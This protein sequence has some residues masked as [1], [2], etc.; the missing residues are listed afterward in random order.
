MTLT[1]PEVVQT[2]YAAR[3]ELFDLL[4][5]FEPGTYIEPEPAKT[6]VR[7]HSQ[8]YEHTLFEVASRLESGDEILDLGSAPFCTSHAFHRLGFTVTAADYKPDDWLDPEL[9]PYK[10]A[11][12]NCDG[13]ALPF[14]DDSFSA[15]VFTEIFEHLHVNL[16]FTMKEILRVLKPNGFVFLT[17]PNLKG[18]RNMIRI[19]KRGKLASSVYDVWRG[20][21]IGSYL[22]HVREYTAVEISQYLPQCGYDRVEVKTENV[23]YKQWLESN[24]W[25]TVTYPFPHSRETIVAVAHKAA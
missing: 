22:G 16:N 8:R 25:R 2:L 20:V 6:Y 11:Q 23:Y 15:V 7:T 1:K 10:V 12:V 17:T 19:L 3:Q 9:L 4:D 14:D 18:L 24:F 13:P 5:S 21:E